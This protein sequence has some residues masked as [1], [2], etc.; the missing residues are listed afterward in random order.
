MDGEYYQLELAAS[1]VMLLVPVERAE[2]MLRPV[3]TTQA[4]AR[5]L[6]S[7]RGVVRLGG[8]RGRHERM[9]AELLRGQT[10]ATARVICQLRALRL[11][12]DLTFTDRQILR[13]ATALLAGEMAL[14]EDMP[15][16]QAENRVEALAGA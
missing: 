4:M 14:A 1:D 7:I 15:F 12:R 2:E 10:D 13:R 5:I 8:A 11:K 6:E 9:R 3:C 16:E